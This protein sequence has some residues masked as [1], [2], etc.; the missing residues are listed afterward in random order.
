MR[1]IRPILTCLIVVIIVSI[2]VRTAFAKSDPEAVRRA[3]LTKLHEQAEQVRKQMEP[4]QKKLSPLEQ[5]LQ[6]IQKQYKQVE[7]NS[8]LAYDPM[9]LARAIS[10]GETSC[11]K[12]G[13]AIHRNNCCGVM[14]FWIGKD[15]QRKREPKYYARYEDSLK[16]TAAI[17]KR[18][19]GRFPDL[20]LAQR[21]TGGDDPQN[22]LATVTRTYN[23][24]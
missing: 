11:G 8:P 6:E 9:K 20:A 17:W 19:Y 18:N 7:G 15:G 12:D 3:R 14:K 5:K 10:C 2:A 22:W 23:A 4:Y 1:N 24:L 21:W 16:E 13:T